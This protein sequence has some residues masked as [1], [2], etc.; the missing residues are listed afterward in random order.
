MSVESRQRPRK[1]SVYR[2][3]P[4]AA[5]TFD[6]AL[7]RIVSVPK[8]ELARR[9]ATYQKSREHKDRPGPRRKAG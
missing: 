9:E 8:E 3:G 1:T 6:G 5:K 2:A 4:E 7:R